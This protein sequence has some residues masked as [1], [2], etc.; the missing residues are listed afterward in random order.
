M[1]SRFETT[2]ITRKYHDAIVDWQ[3]KNFADLKILTDHWERIYPGQTPFRLVAKVAKLRSEEIE[4]GNFKGQKRY[5]KAGDMRGNM[6]YAARDIIRARSLLQQAGDTR[7][8]IATS[9]HLGR[10]AVQQNRVKQGTQH[11]T[12]ALEAA[13]RIGDRTAVARAKEG[14]QAA[15]DLVNRGR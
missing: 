2:E 4:V 10:L 6:F 12:E 11:Y 13:E 9:L 15:K 3:E 5:E 1:K 8:V 7:G 14:I